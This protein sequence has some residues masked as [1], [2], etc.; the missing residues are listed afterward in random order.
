ME[1]NGN[2]RTGLLYTLF[3]IALISAI[4]LRL[5][6]LISDRNK[7][8][9]SY[10]DP[11]LSES[12]V[13]GTIFDRNGNIIALQAP[14]YGFAVKKKTSRAAYISSVISPYI[15]TSVLEAEEMLRSGTGFIEMN[16]IPT[17]IEISTINKLISAIESEDEIEFRVIEERVYQTAVHSDEIIGN[18]NDEMK[19][20]SG[21]E[22][23]ADSLLTPV[24][25]LGYSISYGMSIITT[26]DLDL[27]FALENMDDVK[28]CGE[29]VT[30]AILSENGEVLAW[31]GKGSRKL[32]QN[33]ILS[34]SN[35]NQSTPY[36]PTF[37]SSLIKTNAVEADSDIKYLLFADTGDENKNEALIEGLRNM[38]RAQGRIRSQH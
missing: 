12:L 10:L 22:E 31:H 21:L 14:Q 6:F 2:R 29:D 8:E 20:I 18:V 24:P 15:K 32:Y 27:Q 36:F 28:N 3:L 17:S 7:N 35:G 33:L 23:Y 37:P 4:A 26:L 38:L 34:V 16:M 19:G 13:R 1:K 9:V 30:V 11:P 25:V 5:L